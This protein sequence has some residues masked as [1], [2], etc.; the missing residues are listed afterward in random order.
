MKFNDQH[1]GTKNYKNQIL[2]P[3]ISQ[4]IN[5]RARSEGCLL[6]LLCAS[7]RDSVSY[8]SAAASQSS[9]DP[10]KSGEQRACRDQ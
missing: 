9:V 5:F 10:A 7:R 2:F 3:N 1:S 8:S 4:N 6:I